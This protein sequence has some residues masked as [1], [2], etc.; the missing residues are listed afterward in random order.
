VL[1]D[2]DLC[3]D[4]P[5]VYL[6]A[7]PNGSGKT[8]LLEIL[9]GLRG[10]DD[11]SVTIGGLTPLD[12]RLRYTVGFLSQQNTLRKNSTVAE[13]VE[14]VKDLYDLDVDTAEYL[15]R[16]GL[17][18]HLNHKTKTL[19][20]GTK[21]R[22]L[23]AMLLLPPYEVV[24]LDEPAS[25]LD[26]SS[27][28]EIWNILRECSRDKIVLVSD[29]YLNEAAQY[30]DFVYLINKGRIVQSGV[31]AE[32]L[33]QF[34]L[35]YVAKARAVH[36]ASVQSRVAELTDTFQVRI[37]GTVCSVFFNCEPERVAAMLERGRNEHTVHRVSFE[38]M[39]FFYTGD[40]YGDEVAPSA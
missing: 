27:R 19:S 22:L 31:T 2:I 15:R 30:S 23:I 11:G 17:H 10:A 29:H 16:Y 37:S 25:G 24:V 14:L 12:Q 21:R 9:V 36:S 18:E 4:S 3:I 32:L 35:R 13:E 34:P 39:Y 1:R 20:G 6:L 38:D 8:T 28:D 7:G 26:T 40:A 5:A 33:E